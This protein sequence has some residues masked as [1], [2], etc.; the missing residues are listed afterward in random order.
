[1]L[2]PFNKSEVSAKVANI[3]LDIGAVQLR[4]EQPFQWSS[5]WR[6]PVYCDNRLTLSYPEART[7]LKEALSALAK[8]H[9][10]EAETIAGVATAGIPQAALMAEHL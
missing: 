3:L 1:M 7:F 10:A 5:G 6:S 4:P 2:S 9:F 8:M